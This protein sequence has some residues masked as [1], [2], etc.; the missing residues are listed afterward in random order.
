MIDGLD[1][2]LDI[3]ALK[4]ELEE[5]ARL[6][7]IAIDDASAIVLTSFGNYLLSDERNKSIRKVNR[8]KVTHADIENW[9]AK[10]QHVR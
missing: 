9:K 10:E 3:E 6:C 5:M 1:K 8:D 7:N 2:L 4:S